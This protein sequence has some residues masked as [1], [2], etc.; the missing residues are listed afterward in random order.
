MRSY[1]PVL[2]V[3]Q[4]P[5]S[6][7][8]FSSTSLHE[9]CELGHSTL[10]LGQLASCF[11]VS[12]QSLVADRRR[13]LLTIAACKR[14]GLPA[15]CSLPLPAEPVNPI[16]VLTSMTQSSDEE[17]LPWLKPSPELH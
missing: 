17:G 10:G 3:S 14:A 8:P 6:F 9:G 7:F 16:R 15:P 4:G 13:C 11:Y 1:L 5:L 2:K 12:N